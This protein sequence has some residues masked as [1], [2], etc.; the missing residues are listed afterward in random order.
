MSPGGP[1]PAGGE[2]ETGEPLRILLE[3]EREPTPGFAA[4]VRRRIHRRTAAGQLA[5][6]SWHMPK[7]VLREMAEILKDLFVALGGR[8]GSQP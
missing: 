7:L 2:P 4:Q 3:Q 5:S 6:F 1:G 8:K